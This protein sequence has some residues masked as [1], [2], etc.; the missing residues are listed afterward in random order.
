MTHKERL[1][2]TLKGKSTDQLPFLPRLDLWY[3]ANERNGTLPVKYK[4]AALEQILED[5]GLGF[6]AVIPDFRDL[7]CGDDDVDRALGIYRLWFASYQPI[8]RNVK[9][10]VDYQGD[11][12]IVEYHTPKGNLRTK[13]LYDDAMKKAVVERW[14]GNV[15]TG[16]IWSK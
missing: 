12:T 13:V 9:R 10:T 4:D 11:A 15:K 6:H 2:A 5:M 14:F 1:L 8:L 3:R 16:S 7:R